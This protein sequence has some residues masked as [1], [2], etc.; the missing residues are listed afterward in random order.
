VQR[1]GTKFPP[2]T[3]NPCKSAVPILQRETPL[4]KNRSNAAGDFKNLKSFGVT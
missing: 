1:D 2:R 3:A 4:L